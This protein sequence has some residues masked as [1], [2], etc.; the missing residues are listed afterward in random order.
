MRWK[1]ND[2]GD[3][4]FI[5]YIKRAAVFLSAAKNLPK[6]IALRVPLPP[7]AHHENSGAAKNLPKAIALRVPL[8]P[9]AHHE[10]SGAAKN[11]PKAIALCVRLRVF[12][13][14]RFFAALRKTAAFLILE[15]IYPT[16]R[17]LPHPLTP[18]PAL[19]IDS[20]AQLLCIRNNFPNFASLKPQRRI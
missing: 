1:K 8:P 15:V 3:R 10:N 12:A 6:A 13:F 2:L 5:P 18:S 11:L 20:F 4:F 17:K 16:H 14:G 7:P 9:P 19:L